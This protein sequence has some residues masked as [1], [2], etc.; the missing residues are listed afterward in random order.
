LIAS[1]QSSTITGTLAGQIIMEGHIRLR[2]QPWLRRLITRLLAIIPAMATI[3]FFGEEALG[4][5]LVLSQVVL[6]LQLG[7]AIIPLIHFTSD[8][9]LMKGFAISRLTQG[10]AWLSATVIVGLN[11][12]LVI[13]TLGE[14]LESANTSIIIY[15]IV[16]PLCL[17]VFALLAYIFAAPLVSKRRHALLNA[18]HGGAREIVEVAHTAYHRIGI[19]VD[20]SPKDLT[21][22]QHA[23]MQGGKSASYSLIHIV[24]TAAASYHGDT[25]LDYETESDR[26][27][28]EKYRANLETLGYTASA[29]IGYGK[30]ARSIA[31]IVSENQIE[32]L[33]MGAHG[34]RGIKD[35]IFG[36]TLET[37]RHKVGIPILIVR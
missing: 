26:E 28:L 31:R 14:W 30:V 5:L 7:F 6:S 4:R 24:E 16:I 17:G 20:F 37:V 33:V 32:L 15:F 19:P 3:I 22:I 27:N 11:L 10:F 36:T 13:Q 29:H 34:H 12:K 23:L 8:K 21:T 2:I 1:G 25:V 18:P 35:I 9:A